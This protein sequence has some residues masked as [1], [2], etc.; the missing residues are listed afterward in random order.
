MVYRFS[1][2]RLKESEAEGVELVGQDINQIRRECE[3]SILG[4]VWGRKEVNFTGLKNTF[5]QIW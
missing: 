1:K 3:N 2:F 5:S 4:K